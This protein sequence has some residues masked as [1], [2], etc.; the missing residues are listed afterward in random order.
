MPLSVTA[1]HVLSPG[2]FFAAAE[3]KAMLCHL[4][5]N[6]DIKFDG[7]PAAEIWYYHSNRP[8]PNARVAFRARFR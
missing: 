6:Y 7:K 8:D 4:L 2:Q 1:V 5:L 3:L